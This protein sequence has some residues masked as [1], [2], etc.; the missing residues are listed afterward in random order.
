MVGNATMPVVH[1]V[2]IGD[3]TF[4]MTNDFSQAYKVWKSLPTGVETSLESSNYGTVCATYSDRDDKFVTYDG[5]ADYIDM[6]WN[7]YLKRAEN[8]N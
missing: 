3:N 2:T 5:H 1:F 4:L 8:A 7:L 6:E